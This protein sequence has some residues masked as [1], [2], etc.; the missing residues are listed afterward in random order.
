[1]WRDGTRKKGGW[2]EH[3]S[4]WKEME[5][6]GSTATLDVFSTLPS[7]P[8]SLTRIGNASKSDDAMLRSE[9]FYACRVLGSRKPGTWEGKQ[10]GVF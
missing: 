5:G 8:P 1:M 4:G 2:S 10:S 7:I 6:W 9:V 3:P